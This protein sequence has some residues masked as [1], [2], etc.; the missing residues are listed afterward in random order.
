MEKVLFA[1]GAALLTIDLTYS[2]GIKRKWFDRANRNFLVTA[3]A[4][5]AAFGAVAGVFMVFVARVF[6][7]KDDTSTTQTGIVALA[8]GL[9]CGAALGVF[10]SIRR[11]DKFHALSRMLMWQKEWLDTGWSAVWLAAIIMYFFVQAFRIPSASMRDTFLEGDHL[12]VNK[13]IYGFR[14]PLSGGKRVLALRKVERGDI[15]VFI[16]PPPALDI[17][18]RQRNVNKDFIK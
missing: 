15:V 13:F 17:S 18:E 4:V 14:V 3:S 7:G 12:F 16:A 10:S 1:F 8:V 5:S 11:S 6:M 9:A 2:V